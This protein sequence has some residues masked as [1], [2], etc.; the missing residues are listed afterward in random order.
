MNKKI[1]K[2]IKK[3]SLL[4]DILRDIKN[5]KLN[6][7]AK[8]L[9]NIFENVIGGSIVVKISNI[10]G[11]YEIDP[12]SHVLK[13]ILLAK[14]KE[15]EP[16]IVELILKNIDPNK[17]AINIGANIG[18]YSNLLADNTSPESKVLAI[19]PTPRAFKMLKNN[20]KRNQNEKKVILFNGI[21][22]NK[23]GNYDI[24]II[25]GKEEYSS[26]GK[27]VH[28]SIKNTDFIIEQ[29][30][31]LTIDSLV[32]K[33]NLKP[34]ILVID[35]EGAELNVLK[36]AIKTLRLYHPI[37]ISEVYDELLLKQNADSRKLVKFLE[38]LNYTTLDINKGNVDFPF[39]GNIIAS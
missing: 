9:E 12:R 25:K 6:K 13:Q 30:N 17:D 4:F 7:R 20:I 36:G 10:P 15:Y 19:E 16:Q 23:N 26:L 14:E 24:N 3:N 21:A 35:V 33:H 34:G 22:A 8:Y 5:Y 27:L 39:N 37:I 31:G 1:I 18:L 32:D 38:D 11:E 2:L 28:P 29:V